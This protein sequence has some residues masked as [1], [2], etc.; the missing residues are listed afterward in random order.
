MAVF[1][2][3]GSFT[4]ISDQLLLN[5]YCEGKLEPPQTY[6]P[7]RKGKKEEPGDSDRKL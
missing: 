1:R 5:R 3:W 7:M 6:S 2:P 4:P